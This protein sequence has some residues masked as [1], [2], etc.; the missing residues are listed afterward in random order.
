ML[1][2]LQSTNPLSV[3]AHQDAKNMSKQ[4]QAS[5]THCL[6][7]GEP[8]PEKRR[9]IAPGCDLCVQCKAWQEKHGGFWP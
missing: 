4:D 9:E 6:E 7:C 2:G 1:I 5:L 8:I 3:F